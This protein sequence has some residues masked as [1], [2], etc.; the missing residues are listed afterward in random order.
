MTRELRKK[1][2]IVGAAETDKLGTIP[3]SRLSLHAQA[4]RNALNDAGL[5]LQDVD[6]LLTAGP[7][8]AELSEYLGIVASFLDGTSVGA[9]RS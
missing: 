8:P 2:A 6:G 3:L 5:T 7:T 4:A 1:I 9:P